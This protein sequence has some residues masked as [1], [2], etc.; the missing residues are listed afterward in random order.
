M[1]L[2][3]SPVETVHVHED[4]RVEVDQYGGCHFRA[5]TLPEPIR[6]SPV[7]MAEIEEVRSRV[8]DEREAPDR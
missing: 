3:H 5:S 7:T 1:T 6:L 4:L 2:D 8:L